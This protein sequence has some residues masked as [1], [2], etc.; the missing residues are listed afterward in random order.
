MKQIF[1]IRMAKAIHI[2]VESERIHQERKE[3]KR[4][5]GM[6]RL[7]QEPEGTKDIKICFL[8]SIMGKREWLEK[9]EGMAE[10]MAQT[11]ILPQAQWVAP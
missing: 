4:C 1:L 8:E 7:N 11:E 10:K 6:H 3:L 9:L 5:L 2:L